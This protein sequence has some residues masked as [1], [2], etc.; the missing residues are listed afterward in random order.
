MIRTGVLKLYSIYSLLLLS[1]FHATISLSPTGLVGLAHESATGL[2]DSHDVGAVKSTIELAGQRMPHSQPLPC[3]RNLGGCLGGIFRSSTTSAR[4]SQA[5]IRGSETAEGTRA[6]ETLA[7]PRSWTISF[8][9]KFRRIQSKLLFG[10]FPKARENWNLAHASYEEILASAIRSKSGWGDDGTLAA[11][12]A[13]LK[14]A[15]RQSTESLGLNSDVRRFIFKTE[16]PK[17]HQ[18]LVTSLDKVLKNLLQDGAG[19]GGA[20]SD[21]ESKVAIINKL[22]KAE[23]QDPEIAPYLEPLKSQL[24][25]LNAFHPTSESAVIPET[26]SSAQ[27]PLKPSLSNAGKLSISIRSPDHW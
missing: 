16:I 24:N 5:G 23:L 26:L 27:L 11:N 21:M 22:F 9:S 25:Q 10:F 6:A 17:L 8:A 19:R 4:T 18:D 3:R 2:A 15:R 7:R 1:Q 14:T 12:L 20:R 13:D